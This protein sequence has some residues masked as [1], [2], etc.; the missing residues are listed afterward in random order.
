MK[1]TIKICYNH[2]DKEQTPLIW[3]FAF[4]GAEYWCPY[5]GN[6]TGMLGGGD[7][8]GYT[9]ELSERL[10]HYTK[11]S[12]DYLKARGSMIAAAI[13]YRGKW[14]QFEDLPE[15]RRAKLKEQAT[16]WIYKY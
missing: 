4:P 5:C 12:K 16:S 13:R 7:D 15:K 10:K 3:T 1:K 2:Q 6:Q 8:V 14:V 11:L 9:K